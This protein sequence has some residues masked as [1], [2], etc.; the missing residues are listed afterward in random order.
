MDLRPWRLEKRQDSQE[1]IYLL[2]KDC[3]HTETES[4]WTGAG[5]ICIA[6]Q[7]RIVFDQTKQDGRRCT[8]RLIEVPR[9]LLSYCIF[10]KLV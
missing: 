2:V 4:A 5:E 7:P 10:L 6:S 3:I 8:R 1:N 9:Y